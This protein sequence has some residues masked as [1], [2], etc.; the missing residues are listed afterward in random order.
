MKTFM[1]V[2]YLLICIG[3]IVSVVLQ[4]SKSSGMSFAG[5][6]EVFSKKKSFDEKLSQFT[7]F[8]AVAFFV[9]S[10][11]LAIIFK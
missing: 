2:V 1:T 11:V 6:A 10:I 7:K 8:L 5:G 4:E 9:G 3:L